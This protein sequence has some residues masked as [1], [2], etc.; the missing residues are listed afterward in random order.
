LPAVGGVV[1]REGV[2]VEV[3]VLPLVAPPLGLAESVLGKTPSHNA[4]NNLQFTK[5]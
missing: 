3:E 5:H 4:I 1:N 2:V